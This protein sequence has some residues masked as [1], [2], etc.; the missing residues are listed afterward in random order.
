[1]RRVRILAAALGVAMLLA[2]SAAHAEEQ[3]TITQAGFKP[4]LR[5]MPTNA[6]G[7]ATISSTT[8]IVPSPITHVNV[9]GPAGVTLDLT[10]S[11]TC[12]EQ[13][14]LEKGAEGCPALS[15]AGTGGGM[16]VYELAHEIIEEEYTVEFFLENNHPG[17]VEILVFLAGHS[18]VIIEKIFK[19]VV[20]KGHKPYGLGF[21]LDVPLIKV[22]PEA[23]DASAKTASITL[24]AH[25]RT[26]FAKVHG[27][28][29][30][31]HIK[32]I[33]LPKTCPAGG[34]PIE[35][36]FSFEDESRVTAKKTIPCPKGK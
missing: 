14:L 5:G 36:E 11:T 12:T 29:T 30:L 35:S 27:K 16:G 26:Y 22:L 8:G 32:G 9:F 13:L 31:E 28:R 18:P 20:V 1:M 15:L 33:I 10:G 19:A 23:S 2:T 24:G 17:H 21:S 34:W 4:N 7:S 3:V 25:N 6:F